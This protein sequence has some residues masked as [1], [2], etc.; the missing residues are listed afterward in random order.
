MKDFLTTSEQ[1]IRVIQIYVSY[2]LIIHHSAVFPFLVSFAG[3]K[4]YAT[5]MDGELEE[6]MY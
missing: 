4:D 2:L 6:K 3:E 1:R 5:R